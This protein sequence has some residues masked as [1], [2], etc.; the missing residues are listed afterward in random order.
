[1]A[2]TSASTGIEG[3][4]SHYL[5]TTDSASDGKKMRLDSGTQ[6]AFDLLLD[7]PIF[8]SEVIAATPG[9]N[10]KPVEETSTKEKDATEETTDNSKL[11]SAPSPAFFPLQTKESQPLTPI[12]D[13]IV[14]TALNENQETQ[15]KGDEPVVAKGEKIVAPTAPQ[16]KKKQLDSSTPTESFNAELTNDSTLDTPHRDQR[17]SSSNNHELPSSDRDPKT[18][19]AAAP[20]AIEDSIRVRKPGTATHK[21][22]KDSGKDEL[23]HG[24]PSKTAVKD[25]PI[26]L[27]PR[28][29]KKA[30]GDL[31]QTKK[32]Q[33]N[34]ANSNRRAERLSETKRGG[35]SHEDANEVY[36]SNTN[37]KNGNIELPFELLADSKKVDVAQVQVPVALGNALN[38]TS[39][40]AITTVAIPSA[41]DAITSVVTTGNAS[42]ISQTTSTSESKG[43]KQSTIGG[44][45][46]LQGTSTLTKSPSS[47]SSASSAR[48][49]STLT[50]YQESR[51]LQRVLKGLDQL[52]DKGG[53]VRL[54]LHPPELGSLQ[55]T[56]RI[57]AQ[58]VSAL[59]EV[60]HSASR[61]A[62]LNSLPQ[63]QSSLADK[64][65]NVSHLEVQVVEP[66]QWSQGNNFG[67][68]SSFGQSTGQNDSGANRSSRYL[69][70]MGNQLDQTTKVDAVRPA[71]GQ[72]TRKN[73]E[74]DV[75]Y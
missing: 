18:I 20:F 23:R 7:L 31:E 17:I 44:V 25:K 71:Q 45:T 69:D 40:N 36:S 52:S 72:W 74:L 46:N 5:R 56:I 67:F 73:G 60:E 28:G 3:N 11:N 50:E 29:A 49:P 24:E 37:D 21:E 64:G 2:T 58:Q 41:T 9:K 12:A 4:R 57:D 75:R 32:P 10:E 51:V 39:E 22:T 26:D 16:S 1:M 33:N 6:S 35:R 27:K 61:E 8:D 15:S 65:L 14:N 66:S 70:R 13:P 68:A 59:I 42:L 55:V 30:T 38:T 62:L 43:T 63:L 48:G 54:R 47:G 19:V 34:T 53:Q